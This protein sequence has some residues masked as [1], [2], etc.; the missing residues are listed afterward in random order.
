MYAVVKT[1][2]RQ[3]RVAPGDSF[4]VEKLEGAPGTSLDLTEVLMV[5]GEKTLLGNPTVNG[6]KVTVIVEEQFRGPKIIVFKKK[7]RHKYRRIKGHRS[8]LTRLFVSEISSPAG[9]VK[10]ETKPHILA[11]LAE[12]MAKNPEKKAAKVKA[13]GTEGETERKAA[14]KKM[15]AKGGAKKKSSSAKKKSGAKKSSTKSKAKK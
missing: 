7:R 15:A 8:E 10:A 4:S 5:G 9:S 14:P 3:Y 1:S 2:G 11:P 6:A 13:A 12:R